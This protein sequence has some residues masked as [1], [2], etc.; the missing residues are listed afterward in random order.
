MRSPADLSEP[1]VEPGSPAFQADALPAEL[2]GKPQ[3]KIMF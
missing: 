2:P 1:G 3:V